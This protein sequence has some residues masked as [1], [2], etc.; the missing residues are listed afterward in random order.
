M[1]PEGLPREALSDVAEQCA[2]MADGGYTQ[3]AEQQENRV[4]HAVVHAQRA[5]C[6]SNVE[7]QQISHRVR[8]THPEDSLLEAFQYAMPRP[9]FE[10]YITDGTS[11]EAP[12]H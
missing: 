10:S 1:V 4:I 6:S 5:F 2:E 8:C 3:G 11:E 9:I 12:A 7:Y